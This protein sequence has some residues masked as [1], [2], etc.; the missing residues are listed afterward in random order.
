MSKTEY[1]DLVA[2]R[3]ALEQVLTD[4]AEIEQVLKLLVPEVV[5]AEQSPVPEETPSGEED[6]TDEKAPKVKSQYVIIVSDPNKAIKQ[7]LMGW[8]VQ[9]PED[10]DASETVANI[11]KGAYNFNAS[12]KGNRYP[13]T[14]IGQAI[15]DVPSKFLKPYAIKVK[16]K[17]PVTVL[18]TD[19]VLPRE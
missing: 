14:S 1:V 18:I 7:D 9:V 10:E 16:T 12:K 6:G 19:N 4:V 8:V 5:S 11:K 17:E 2:V 3:T 15:G 13:V